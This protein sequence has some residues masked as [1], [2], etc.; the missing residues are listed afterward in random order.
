MDEVGLHLAFIGEVTLNGFSFNLKAAT[1]L[2]S[3]RTPQQWLQFFNLLFGFAL[4]AES[5]R[6]WEGSLE[7]AEG[8]HAPTSLN[9]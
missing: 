1:V 6:V 3:P 2:K 7:R 8:I 9:P 4:R 5:A